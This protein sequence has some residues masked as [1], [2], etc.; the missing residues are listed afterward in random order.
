MKEPISQVDDII[1]SDQH[2]V[3]EHSAK[4]RITDIFFRS[5]KS[6]FKNNNKL[7]HC[8]FSLCKKLNKYFSIYRAVLVVYS[9]IDDNLKVIALKGQQNSRE[10]L[11]ISLPKKNSLFYKTFDNGQIFVEDCIG[12][13]SGNFIE[14]KLLSIEK[15]ES[16]AICPV[17]H[18]DKTIGL[19][20]LSSASL[21][22]F[23]ML[24][25]GIFEQVLISLGKSVKAELSK[26]NI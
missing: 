14:R 6:V 24:G 19:L 15:C 12:D 16:F 2:Q 9:E 5:F 10:G 11:A 3:V 23:E 21:Y 18:K 22:C 17:I 8:F 25:E 7:S 4:N 20:C 26:V 1:K 13:F